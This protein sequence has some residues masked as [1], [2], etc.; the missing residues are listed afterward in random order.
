MF[1]RVQGMVWSSHFCALDFSEASTGVRM[2][3]SLKAF[4]FEVLGDVM[5]VATCF[6]RFPGLP[7]YH[8]RKRLQA[9][10]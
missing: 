9:P 6:T 10:V 8:D 2:Y 3:K 7:V 1:V 5:R 4:F